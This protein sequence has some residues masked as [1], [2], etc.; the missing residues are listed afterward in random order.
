MLAWIKSVSQR[1]LSLILVILFSLMGGAAA[2]YATANG[3][4]GSQDAATY[5][6]TALNMLRGNGAGYYLADGTFKVLVIQ[7]PFFPFVMS[8]IGRLGVNLVAAARWLNVTLFAATILVVGLIFI[9]FS[10]SPLLAVPACLLVGAFPNMLKMAVSAM[11]EPLFVFL[12]VLGLFGLMG[13][14]RSG[15]GRWLVLAGLASGFL[16]L[17]RYIGI[18]LLPAGALAILLFLP[19]RWKKRLG[20]AVL[21]ALLAGLPFLIWEG[22]IY[23]A[24]NHS[25]T[26]RTMVFD[27]QSMA[28]GVVNFYTTATQI[29][30]GWIPLGGQIWGLRFRWRYAVIFLVLAGVLTMTLLAARRSRKAGGASA[31]GELQL[32][33][34]CGFWVIAYL[35]AYLFTLLF[36][37]PVSPVEA[38]TL[39]PVFVGLALAWM[40]ALAGWQ[41][42]WFH[43]RLAWLQTL[44]WLIAGLGLCLYLPATVNG[45]LIPYHPGV[46]KTAYAWGHSETMAAVRA[47]PADVPIVSNDSYVIWVWAGR[48][49]YDLMENIQEAF[50]NHNTPYGTDVNDPAQ[51]AFRQKGAALVIFNEEF[52]SQ[53]QGAYG[54]M[55]KARLGTLFQGLS[56][57]G[58]YSD[59]AIYYYP[60]NH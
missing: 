10:R 33:S 22:W 35:F 1:I 49:A 59:G 55:G 51:I 36:T 7:P 56:V 53:L 46:G 9:K 14:L 29:A 3:P 43:G 50:V 17:T 44:P 60:A 39:L 11:S 31:G 41:A 48:P 47:L 16:T 20:S 4:W 13:F 26:G 34:A 42:A 32:F 18:A 38:R 28:G 58:Q 6:V 40:A 15:G 12:F 45:V 27:R 5:L 2:I 19:G 23:F 25:L 54:G 8:L 37:K 24:L 30:L 21:F 57:G 52:A